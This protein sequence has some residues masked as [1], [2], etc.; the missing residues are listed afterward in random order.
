MHR[1]GFNPHTADALK[2][3]TGSTV[4]LKLT[5]KTLRKFKITTKPV[6][7]LELQY[8][9]PELTSADLTTIL[10]EEADTQRQTA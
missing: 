6:L 8:C 2:T 10:D 7:P 1:T 3:N 9:P 5:V 4:H